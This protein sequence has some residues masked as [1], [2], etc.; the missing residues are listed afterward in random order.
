MRT[1][2]VVKHNYIF[3]PESHGVAS[4]GLA[5]SLEGP[6]RPTLEWPRRWQL[7]NVLAMV[8]NII[9][10]AVPGRL[11]SEP[12]E[13]LQSG[14]ATSG[15]LVSRSYLAPTGWA[16]AIWAAI[17]LGESA[18]NFLLQFFVGG[19]SLEEDSL[20]LATVAIWWTLAS[21]GQGLWCTT[22]RQTFR[23]AGLLWVPTLS[24][25]LGAVGLLQTNFFFRQCTSVPG[26][27]AASARVPVAIHAGWLCTATL[28]NFNQTVAALASVTNRQLGA[29]AIASIVTGGALGCTL[30]ISRQSPV[31]ALVPTWSLAAVSDGMRRRI[32][33]PGDLPTSYAPLVQ[34]HAA[35]TALVCGIVALGVLVTS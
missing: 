27:L 25:A 33:N 21:V 19:S 7:L 16:F 15:Y 26:W 9:A 23:D 4:G 8:G 32:A 6:L 10:V 1:P 12:A 18:W 22:Y 13:K 14:A 3:T 20:V 5:Q 17:Y 35:A 29:L 24:L 28:V 31:L 2:T 30:A 34:W 11:D